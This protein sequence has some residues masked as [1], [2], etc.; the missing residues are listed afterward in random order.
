MSALGRH[1]GERETALY[2]APEDYSRSLRLSVAEDGTVLGGTY[3]LYQVGPDASY[4]VVT[5]DVPGDLAQDLGKFAEFL[6]ELASDD[7]QV[8][9]SLMSLW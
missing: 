4:V 9:D 1:S 5:V 8:R 6:D 3:T 7:Q 2:P